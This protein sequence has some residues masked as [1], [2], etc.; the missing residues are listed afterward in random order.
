MCRATRVAS[1]HPSSSDGTA[2][3]R[4]STG[5][6]RSHE[7]R[8]PSAIPPRRCNEYRPQRGQFTSPGRWR[9][10]PRKRNG[11]APAHWS[12]VARVVASQILAPSAR[13]RRITACDSRESSKSICKEIAPPKAKI[14]QIRLLVRAQS[15]AHS[16]AFKFFTDDF[17]TL[18]GGAGVW[19]L[20]ARAQQPGSAFQRRLFRPRGFCSRPV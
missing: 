16:I 8:P 15:L 11:T 19:P 18:L 6:G 3:R 9:V 12:P 2:L 4:T 20:A 13:A 5:S 10:R 14:R 17:I 1:G 7:P